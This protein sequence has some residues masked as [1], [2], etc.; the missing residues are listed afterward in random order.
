[1]TPEGRV[2]K[3]CRKYLRDI[4][5][6]VFSPV[7]MGY[8]TRTLDDLVCWRGRF[9]AI[10]YKAPGKE[11]TAHQALTAEQITAAGGITMVIDS[12]EKLKSQFEILRCDDVV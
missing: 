3:A 10:E 8:G 9:I 5:C 7:Q 12:F 2:K 1:M 4:G 6:Y 11:P